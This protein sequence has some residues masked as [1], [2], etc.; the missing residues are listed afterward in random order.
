MAHDRAA[1]EQTD[2]LDRWFSLALFEQECRQLVLTE[3][4]LRCQDAVAPVL[5][6]LEPPT[7]EPMSSSLVVQACSNGG[8][9]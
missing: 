3:A 9:H 7:F 6:P 4:G 2:E 1:S 8:L 5:Y